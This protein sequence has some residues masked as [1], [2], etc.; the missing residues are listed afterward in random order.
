MAGD[1]PIVT[2]AGEWWNLE[3]RFLPPQVAEEILTMCLEG[4][5]PASG[6]YAGFDHG[7]AAGDA[8]T[9][10]EVVEDILQRQTAMERHQLLRLRDRCAEMRRLYE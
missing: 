9:V 4:L 5:R 8:T 7:H 1:I 2:V 6:R 3:G 10:E